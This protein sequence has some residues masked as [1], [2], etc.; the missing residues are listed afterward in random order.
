MNSAH[1][2]RIPLGK[3]GVFWNLVADLHVQRNSRSNSKF[4]LL[5]VEVQLMLLGG[6]N[7]QFVHQCDLP[8]VFFPCCNI[9]RL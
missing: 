9:L 4:S 1:D 8:D 6:S 3:A 2:L 7:F 5:L